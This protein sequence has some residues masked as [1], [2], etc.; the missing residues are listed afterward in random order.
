MYD[1][2]PYRTYCSR[3]VRLFAMLLRRAART[4][5]AHADLHSSVEVSAPPACRHD[6]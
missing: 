6:L 3:R 5:V 2:V 4:L 1:E